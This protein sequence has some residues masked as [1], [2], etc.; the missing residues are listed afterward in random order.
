[1]NDNI[2]R[3]PSKKTGDDEI[4]VTI[5]L[6]DDNISRAFETLRVSAVGL[7]NDDLAPIH[8]GDIVHASIILISW[9]AK[10]SDVSAEELVEF[11]QSI[12]LQDFDD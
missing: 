8:G 2:V 12:E 11:F 9:M 4:N 7:M 10:Q 6:D 1:M 3:F 5:S